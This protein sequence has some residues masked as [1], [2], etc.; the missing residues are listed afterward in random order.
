MLRVEAALRRRA[1][2]RYTPSSDSSPSFPLSHKVAKGGM[3][4][5]ILN[6]QNMSPNLWPKVGIF[7]AFVSEFDTIARKF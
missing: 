4:A 2:I 5:N 3:Y 6:R 1:G 7:D